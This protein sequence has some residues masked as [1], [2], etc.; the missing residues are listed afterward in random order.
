MASSITNS[1]LKPTII[2]VAVDR[3][4]IG[5]SPLKQDRP[6]KIPLQFT[7][8]LAVH[9]IMMQIAA[10]VRHPELIWFHSQN[11][12]QIELS[13]RER[14]QQNMHGEKYA[15]TILSILFVENLKA[16]KIGLQNGSLNKILMIA[17]IIMKTIWLILYLY[18]EF[19]EAIMEMEVHI[20]LGLQNDT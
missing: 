5:D 10:M 12:G 20:I 1:K 7:M 16:M 18:I 14:F 2:Q 9:S 11:Q 8:A 4:Q 17:Q 19:H 15:V 6:K 3:M 13:V